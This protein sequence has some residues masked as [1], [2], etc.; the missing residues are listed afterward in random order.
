MDWLGSIQVQFV[1]VVFGVVAVGLGG[2]GYYR[3][4]ISRS[5]FTFMLVG[6]AALL[7]Y[8][9]EG[10]ATALSLPSLISNL[11]AGIAGLSFIGLFLYW[12]YRHETGASE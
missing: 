1:A 10:T 7:A 2:Y 4:R 5:D 8:G 6:A 11:L 12:A 3:D 9:L